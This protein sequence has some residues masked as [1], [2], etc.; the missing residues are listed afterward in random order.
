MELKIESG[1]AVRVAMNHDL[2]I[3]ELHF[4]ST[5]LGISFPAGTIVMSHDVALRLRDELNELTLDIPPL[6][7]EAATDVNPHQK[8]SV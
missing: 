6:P 3:T 5:V 8:E 4:R 1:T 2:R 7:A